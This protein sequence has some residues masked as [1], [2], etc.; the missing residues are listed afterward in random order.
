MKK[1]TQVNVN[2]K[3]KNILK[4]LHVL[5]KKIEKHNKLYHQYDKPIISD[6]DFD[7]LIKRN[8]YLEK[9]FPHLKLEN[10]PN[11]TVGGKVSN[12]FSKVNHKAPMLSL[13]NAFND[14]DLNE[15]IKRIK[16]YIND[17]NI[18]LIFSCEPKIDGLS[19]NLTY[20]NGLLVLAC[21]RGDGYI[22]EDVTENIKTIEDI[23]IKLKNNNFPKIIEIRGE[24]FLKKQD[25]LKL[26]NSLETKDKFS[27]PRNAAAGSIR[28]LD[29]YITASRPL[30][31]IVH[32]IGVSSN[33]YSKIS[34]VY[35]D[36]ISWG[37]KVNSENIVAKNIDEMKNYYNKIN[38][39]RSNFE[40][41]ID[42][43][44]YKLNDIFLQ[45]RLGFVGKN[46]RWAIAYK[47]KS[48]KVKTRIRKID[49]QVGRTGAITPVARL[50][51]VNIGGVNVS[52]AT[53]HNF[54]EIH[55]K[56]IRENDEIEIQRA[57]D[58]IP[59]VLRVINK[60]KQRKNKF[61][62]PKNCPICNSKL[63]RDE[64]E[65]IIRCANYYKCDAQLIEK[66]IHFTSIKGLN[67]D[68]FGENQIKLFWK[69]GFIKKPSD[70]FLLN[71]YK[72]DIIN[73]EGWGNQSF[74]NLI[75]NINKSKQVE[76]QKFIYSLGI[77]YVGEINA[78][79]ISNHFLNINNF[80]NKAKKIENLEHIDGLGPKAIKSITE[81]LNYSQ[82]ID[83]IKKII[84]YCKIKDF[85]KIQ[86]TSKFNNKHIIF[87]GKLKL[88]SRE[89]AKKRAVELGAIIS[90]SVSVKTD[91]L[92]C[93]EKSGSKLKKAKELKVQI[94]TE[95]EW[96]SMI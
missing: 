7:K 59:Q 20:Q 84:S 86:S 83:E 8:N 28:Q 91:Y 72:N 17:K 93:G 53:L 32:G 96:L 67:I 56:D 80:L 92:V 26:N 49:I 82:N 41:D 50:Y 46:P 35:K 66:I 58:V 75:D 5:F 90:S 11:N 85:K 33:N 38:I 95:S 19:I 52:N 79:I 40:Y 21:T 73:L 18:E 25:F 74:R 2:F 6:N 9:K 10:S 88:M 22:G 4:E 23:P 55:K 44:V 69:I 63:V 36:I 1:K 68:G 78:Q 27:N 42:G 34:S 87:T 48:I 51:P 62:T 31:F 12:K 13:G 3:E 81:F 89:E 47:F 77:R 37:F 54:D 61:I 57:G 14:L 65:S 24:V 39:K 64:D 45:K 15:F 94:L 30:K 43:I 71:K 29:K 16:K 70:I 76:L 60:N